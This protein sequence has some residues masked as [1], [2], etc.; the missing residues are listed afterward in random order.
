MS[1]TRSGTIYSKS[2]INKVSVSLPISKNDRPIP[3]SISIPKTPTPIL[4]N[5]NRPA[6][7]EPVPISPTNTNNRQKRPNRTQFPKE[8]LRELVAESDNDST[9]SY[10]SD[11]MKADTE[12][13]QKWM[14]PKYNLPT[15]T[16]FSRKLPEYQ[17]NDIDFDEASKAWRAN[18]RRVGESWVYKV[19]K[20][21]L[22]SSRK[23]KNKK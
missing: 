19:Q 21:S 18:K 12:E 15:F 4:R 6:F 9:S 23:G 5:N 8:V 11:D 13:E 10:D 2:N 16:P 7:F 20:S 17:T 14:P 22:P 1:A 3:A